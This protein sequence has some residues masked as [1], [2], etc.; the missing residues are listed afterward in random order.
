M[1]KGGA[2]GELELEVTKNQIEK[3]IVSMSAKLQS[4]KEKMLSA[5]E[6]LELKKKEDRMEYDQ[7]K[8]ALGRWLRKSDSDPPLSPA[9]ICPSLAAGLLT[10]ECAGQELLRRLILETKKPQRQALTIKAPLGR[11]SG[12]RITIAGSAAHP[13]SPVSLSGGDECVLDARVL[14]ESFHGLTIPDDI[15]LGLEKYSKAR[16]G[17]AAHVQQVSLQMSEKYTSGGM[18]WDKMMDDEFTSIVDMP[19]HPFM[20]FGHVSHD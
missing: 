12:G 18:D 5:E 8:D 6:R 11:W 17:R 13:S 9:A 7:A 3:E 19:M 15:P 2:T 14:I 4:C 10:R 20:P 16:V 1:R